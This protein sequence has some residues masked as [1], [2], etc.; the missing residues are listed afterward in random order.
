MTITFTDEEVVILQNLYDHAYLKP[1]V[2]WPLFVNRATA[3]LKEKGVI[4]DE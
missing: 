3:L 2:Y 1:D 4:K